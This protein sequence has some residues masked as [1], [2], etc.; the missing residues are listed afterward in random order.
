VNARQF[1][2]KYQ[3]EIRFH[4]DVLGLTLP[5]PSDPDF[6][7][8]CGA[9]QS[10]RGLFP[11]QK[12]G[13]ACMARNRR[14]NA[15]ADWM[16]DLPKHDDESL[17]SRYGSTIEAA[18]RLV[19]SLVRPLLRVHELIRP[20]F[21]AALAWAIKQ[22]GYDPK[23]IQCYN[24]RYMRGPNIKFK[25]WSRHSWGIAIDCDP[26][27]NPW[28]NKPGS[29]ILKHPAFLAAFRALGCRIGADW[30]DPD[31]MHVEFCS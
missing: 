22:S 18:K 5:D 29:P 16:R 4:R 15:P 10:Q 27:L 30:G 20:E 26:P 28:G 7:F 11:D 9:W 2:L 6:E 23:S 3:W 25:K 21:D 1:N 8:Q 19:K 12:F 17:N 24:R 31:T 14:D 13:P